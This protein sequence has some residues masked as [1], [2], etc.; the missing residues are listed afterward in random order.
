MEE[1][2]LGNNGLGFLFFS[3]EKLEEVRLASHC[4]CNCGK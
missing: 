3:H 2:Q 4:R 1:F